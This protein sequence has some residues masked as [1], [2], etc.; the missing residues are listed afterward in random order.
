MV[1]R[2]HCHRVHCMVLNFARSNNQSICTLH[3]PEHRDPML[4]Q[5]HACTNNG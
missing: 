3:G 1:R 4:L 2:L 5:R